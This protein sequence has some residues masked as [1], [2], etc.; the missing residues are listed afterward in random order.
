MTVFIAIFP[1]LMYIFRLQIDSTRTSK[2]LEA[3]WLDKFN[4]DFNPRLTIIKNAFD[5]PEELMGELVNY[6]QSKENTQN[7][8]K[9]KI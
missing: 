2:I 3:K 5:N 6:F 1:I 8:K 7:E 4:N 9:D